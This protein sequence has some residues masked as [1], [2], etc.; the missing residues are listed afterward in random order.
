M[1]YAKGRPGQLTYASA[2]VGTPHHLAAEL[3][4]SK[5]GLDITNVTYKGGAPA[6]IAVLSGEVQIHFGSFSTSLPHVKARRLT[7]L[8]L[9]G[10][11]RSAEAPDVPTMREEGFPGFDVRSWFAVL[12]PAHTPQ[13]IVGRLNGELMKVIAIPDV[14]DRL[15]K[16]GVD[17]LGSTPQELAAHMKTERA[18]WAKLINEAAI[19]PE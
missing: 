17:P 9:T 8:A 15:R 16:T 19:K 2:G 13:S 11:T 3:F 14:Q 6:A 5:A 10:P 4:K 1:A 7:A 18:V 12:A